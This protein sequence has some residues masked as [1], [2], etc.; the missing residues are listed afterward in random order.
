MRV[1]I[2]L[3]VQTKTNASASNSF[4]KT[5][6]TDSGFAGRNL[7]STVQAK[8]YG[9]MLAILVDVRIF[10]KEVSSVLDYK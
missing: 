2:S 4:V 10:L 1:R 6:V 8:V 5:S 9:Y 3:P 7:C